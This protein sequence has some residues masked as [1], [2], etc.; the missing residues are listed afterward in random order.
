MEEKRREKR[1]NIEMINLPFLGTKEEDNLCFQYL[2]LD[3]S[4]SGAKIAIPEWVVN[5]ERIR[6][7]DVINFHIPFE[8]EN[9][10]YDHGEIIRI[11][12]DDAV[13]SDI[14][15]VSVKHQKSVTSSAWRTYAFSENS[16]IKLLKDSMLLK[17]GVYIYIGHLIPFFSRITKYSP[18]EY[19][20]LKVVFLEDVRRRIDEHYN[21]LQDLFENAKI[22][23]KSLSDMSKV[24]D[25]EKLR[26]DVESEIYV[27]IFNITFSDE[28]IR[29][30]LDAIKKLE[31]RLY[32]NY[33]MIVMFYAN[34]L[35]CEFNVL[36]S[37][38]FQCTFDS[39]K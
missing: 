23:L 12:W 1:F 37:L 22:H 35:S 39:V 6:E 13:K 21:G 18:S 32:S 5:R 29:P 16:I 28:H 20:E 4:K 31:N 36:E 38:V 9:N 15:G 19:P 3:V 30:Y 33:N 24:V 7:N 14:F 10:L 34:S 8:I 11:Q 2:L 25:L 27:E 26:A 17:K